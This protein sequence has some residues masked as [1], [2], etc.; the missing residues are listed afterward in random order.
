VPAYAASRRTGFASRQ[1]PLGLAATAAAAGAWG[2]AAIFVDLATLPALVLTFYRLWFAAGLLLVACLV[3]RTRLSWHD[4]TAVVPGG[5]L[6]A[7]DMACFFSAVRL[8]SIADATVISALQPVMV[9][10]A[11]VPLF[12]ETVR[13]SDMAW[14]AVAIGGVA[15]LVVGGANPAHGHHLSGDLLAVASVLAWSGYFLVSKHARAGIGALEYTFGVTVVAALVITPVVLIA[16]E[17]FRVS[18]AANWWWICLLALVPGS[19][20]LLMNWAHRSVDVSVSSLIGATNP[21]FAA[22]AAWLVLGQ[23]LN[24]LQIAGGL[25]GVGAVSLVAGRRQST[26]STPIEPAA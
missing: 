6:L 19:G 3:T 12:A 17:S 11:A 21:L 1:A 4:L 26:A 23:S 2:V 24:A 9:M 7:A 8:T 18:T 15:V 13:R 14:T 5:V 10:F 22:A 25:V 16:G 20:H